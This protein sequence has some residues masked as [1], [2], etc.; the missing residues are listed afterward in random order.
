MIDLEMMIM[1]RRDLDMTNNYCILA[2]HFKLHAF[3]INLFLFQIYEV[4]QYFNYIAP[5]ICISNK[6]E[7]IPKII[8]IHFY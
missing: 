4:T 1:G 7:F 2:G 3:E 5:S 6:F 8:K